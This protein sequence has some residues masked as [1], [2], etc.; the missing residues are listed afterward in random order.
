MS[1]PSTLSALAWPFAAV[2]TILAGVGFYLYSDAVAQI[3]TAQQQAHSSREIEKSSL[4]KQS[5]LQRQLNSAIYDFE[6]RQTEFT[7]LKQQL[8]QLQQKTE[9]QQQAWQA[10]QQE[11]LAQVSKS[12]HNAT[13]LTQAQQ[14]ISDL[15]QELAT[16]S[17]QLLLAQTSLEEAGPSA[18]LT[19]LQQQ[20]EKVIQ[21]NQELKA[22]LDTEVADK[23]QLNLT[24]ADARAEITRLDQQIELADAKINELS[25]SLELDPITS[26][27]NK[28][29]V[30]I[31]TPAQVVPDG[32]S[33]N[34]E[35]EATAEPVSSTTVSP[36]IDPIL[37]TETQV[38]A[39]GVEPVV[40]VD[41]TPAPQA[42]VPAIEQAVEAIIEPTP[43]A[44]LEPEV[45]LDPEL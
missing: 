37:E 22:N 15:T 23:A 43:E 41:A 45:I 1:Q 36:T 44:E 14:K 3:A 32:T 2:A 4:T 19:Q 25:L 5:D 26:G 16:L 12:Q 35:T 13:E 42:A 29:E 10:K 20:F 40:N 28:L 27:E 21:E 39:A 34:G 6:Q 9:Q 8:T 11:W 24:L 30:T 33:A 38:T 31:D 18:D 17:E 7:E